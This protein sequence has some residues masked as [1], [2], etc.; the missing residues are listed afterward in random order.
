M[1]AEISKQV[2]NMILKPPFTNP[3]QEL[4]REILSRTAISKEKKIAKLLSEE[5]LGDKKPSQFLKRLKELAAT[6]KED[7]ILRHIFLSRLQE[8]W[9]QV[10]AAVSDGQSLEKLAMAAGKIADIASEDVYIASIPTRHS[11][12]E[13]K[14]LVEVMQYCCKISEKLDIFIDIVKDGFALASPIRVRNYSKSRDS[15]KY[16]VPRIVEIACRIQK[17]R[18]SI[19]CAISIKNL[20]TEN[21]HVTHTAILQIRE[22]LSRQHSATS[23]AVGVTKSHFFYIHDCFTGLKF[24]IA[25]PKY[26]YCLLLIQKDIGIL[27][28]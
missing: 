24:L 22:M 15:Q 5:R 13:T 3:F 10:L 16:F 4:K 9:Q 1:P 11:C 27:I 23:Y 19:S 18:R 20:L 8:K 7:A 26:H 21:G 28:N 2:R 12:S 17:I 25:V 14:S 6:N